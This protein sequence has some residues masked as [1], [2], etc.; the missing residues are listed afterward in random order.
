MQTNLVLQS[1]L[2][3]TF[4]TCGLYQVEK[5]KLLVQVTQTT[6]E[7]RAETQMIPKKKVLQAIVM[8]NTCSLKVN[9]ESCQYEVFILNRLNLAQEAIVML[10]GAK[11]F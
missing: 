7:Y 5:C 1:K 11:E 6:K 8:L 3:N 9:L 10:S 4:S 2:I